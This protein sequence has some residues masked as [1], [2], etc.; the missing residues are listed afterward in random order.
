MLSTVKRVVTVLWKGSIQTEQTT[1][2]LI[3]IKFRVSL[4]D[5][6]VF[7]LK[8]FWMRPDP[9]TLRRLSGEMQKISVW[10]LTLDW[11]Q[12]TINACIMLQKN[13]NY[14]FFFFFL[15]ATNHQIWW[16]FSCKGPPSLNLKDS[17][18][19]FWYIL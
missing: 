12:K 9:V 3:I 11:S 8:L 17:L 6:C 1:Q 7:Q 5:L 15:N 4:L 10:R 18:Y 16:W 2:Y 19:N 13:L 14:S